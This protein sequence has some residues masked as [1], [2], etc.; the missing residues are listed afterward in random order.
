MTGVRWQ[1]KTGKDNVKAGKVKRKKGGLGGGGGC[2]SG[3]AHQTGGELNG[4]FCERA[5]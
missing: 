2:A 5:R 1:P 3:N 4:G